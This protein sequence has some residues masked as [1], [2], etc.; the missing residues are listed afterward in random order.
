MPS[1]SINICRFG[2]GLE[3]LAPYAVISGKPEPKLS[4]KAVVKKAYSGITAKAV[5]KN[6]SGRTVRL[7][8]I[9][10]TRELKPLWPPQ[11]LIFPDELKPFYYS[12]ENY[13]GEVFGTG[14]MVGSSFFHPLTNQDV[15]VGLH[16]DWVFPGVFIGS[17]I[18]EIGMLVAAAEHTRFM[19]KFRFRGGEGKGR[20]NFELEQYPQGLEYL[21]IAPGESI[22]SD[23]IFVDILKSDD[24][25]LSTISYYKLLRKNGYFKRMEKN[26]L[27]EQRIWGSWNFGYYH[28]INEHEILKQIPAIKSCFPSVKFL[29]I[30]DGYAEIYKSGQWREA[31]LLYGTGTHYDTKKFPHGMKYVADA[32]RAG[33]L[34]PAIWLSLWASGTSLMMKE[35]PEWAL[36]DEAGR[37]MKIKSKAG[38]LFGIPREIIILDPSVPSYRAYVDKVARTVFKEWGFEGLKLDFSSFPFNIR[39]ARFKYPGRTAAEYRD[40]CVNTFRKYL[41]KDGFFGWCSAVGAGTPFYGEADY[42]R[43][44]EDISDGSWYLAKRIALWTANTNMLNTERTVIPNIDSIGFAKDFTRTQWLTFLSLCAV[45]G[46]TVEVSG[47]L[48]KLDALQLKI[49]NTA[50]ELSDT[51]ASFRTLDYPKGRIELPPSLWLSSK[52]GSSRGA[53]VVNWSDK[54]KKIDTRLLDREFPGWKKLEPVWAPGGKILSGCVK[55]PAYG[56]VFVSKL[57]G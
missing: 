17:G 51:R 22:V 45:T 24:P 19:C 37:I 57:N 10:W 31:D 5:I 48:T 23:S 38:V 3:G 41:P 8:S 25:Q 33:G 9:L 53:F 30:D 44:A 21:E 27:H 40:W 35:H 20:W 32:I 1:N 16:E 13:R 29:Q 34:R 12:S 11:V 50:L 2:I 6:N 36:R 43:Y 39:R 15:T 46:N 54:A 18:K 52:N 4:V 26:P 55:L 47:D 7:K 56:S 42:Y 28:N 49:L 14:T